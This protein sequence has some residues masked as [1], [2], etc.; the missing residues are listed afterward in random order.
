[1]I[2]TES[3]FEK[4]YENEGAAGFKIITDNNL[5][6]VRLILKPNAI[7]E[8]HSLPFDV[9][10]YVI[11]GMGKLFINDSEYI[12]SKNSFVLCRANFE[13]SWQNINATD[14]TLLVVK[15]LT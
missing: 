11:E 15:S 3:Q 9:Y 8:P 10:F 6:F 1:M 13:R 7:V 12:V 4:V 2:I 5:E 14:L